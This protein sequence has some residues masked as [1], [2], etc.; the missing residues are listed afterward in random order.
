MRAQHAMEAGLA[1]NVDPLVG[2]R[3]DDPLRRRLG[4][5]RFIGR[6]DGSSPFGLAQ[7]VRRIGRLASSRRSPCVNLSPVFQRRSEGPPRQHEAASGLDQPLV[8]DRQQRLIQRTGR[9]Q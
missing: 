5:A 1:G 9:A 4:K 2:Q 3:R 6:R 8:V 7:R